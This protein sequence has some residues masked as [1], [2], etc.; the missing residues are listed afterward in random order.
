MPNKNYERA[1]S[2]ERD[3]VKKLLREGALYATRTPGSKSPVD[4]IAVFIDAKHRLVVHMIQAKLGKSKPKRSEIDFL[5]FMREKG[6]DAYFMTTR[7]NPTKRRFH[8]MELEE[9]EAGP[10]I[11]DSLRDVEH[12]GP[13]MPE[14]PKCE[15]HPKYMARARPR[16]KRNLPGCTCYE[17]FR[18]TK[19]ERDIPKEKTMPTY[20]I[21]KQY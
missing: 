5:R 18:N 13:A 8:R 15:V 21:V 2:Y 6:C 3:L 19:F 14:R 16:C 17:M 10:T 1:A 4:V 12:T 9:V 11:D 20:R 7:N